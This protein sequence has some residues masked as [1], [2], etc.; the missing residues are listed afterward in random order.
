[1]ARAASSPTSDVG[2]AAIEPHLPPGAPGDGSRRLL[3]HLGRRFFD[4]PP[5]LKAERHRLEGMRDSLRKFM[6]YAAQYNGEAAFQQFIPD[7]EANRI[8]Q[9]E[10]E[11]ALLNA[12]ATSDDRLFFAVLATFEFWGGDLDQRDEQGNRLDEQN[13]Q[14][15]PVKASRFFGSVLKAFGFDIADRTIQDVVQRYKEV[16]W[17]RNQGF[18]FAEAR[19]GF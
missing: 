12:C 18:M 19:P 4:R 8:R 9:I 5:D 17:L 14:Y 16:R 1:M 13:L 15:V 3:Y 11:L 2:W 7:A 10:A 6:G